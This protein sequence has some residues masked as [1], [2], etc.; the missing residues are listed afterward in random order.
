MVPWTK[1]RRT[2]QAQQDFHIYWKVRL[3]LNVLGAAWLVRPWQQHSTVSLDTAAAHLAP[4]QQPGWWLKLPLAAASEELVGGSDLPGV[5]LSQWLRLAGFWAPGSHVFP[6]HVTQWTGG[7]A[8]CRIYL[9][10]SLGVLE[11]LFLTTVVLLCRGPLRYLL[12]CC[13]SGRGANKA[14]W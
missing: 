10:A 7:G 3:L 5:Q 2:V 4:K 1:A 13:P 9:C 6:S 12:L 11:P 8:L 14:C